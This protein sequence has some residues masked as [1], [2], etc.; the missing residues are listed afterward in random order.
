M[1]TRKGPRPTS[2]QHLFPGDALDVAADEGEE[3]GE[4]GAEAGPKRKKGSASDQPADPS[5]TLEPNIEALNVKKFDLTF[6]VDPLF[7]QTSAQFDEGGAKG[8]HT[9][10]SALCFC[11]T[12]SIQF[13]PC[14][15][16]CE[17]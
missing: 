1:F 6:A 7:H 12:T 5:S 9:S 4:Q 16:S 17:H 8:A 3:D 11:I 2:F 14:T 15:T 10:S 13:L